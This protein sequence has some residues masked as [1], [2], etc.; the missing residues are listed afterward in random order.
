MVDQEIKSKFENALEIIKDLYMF[1]YED[2]NYYFFKH[3]LTR[4][5][6]KIQKTNNDVMSKLYGVKNYKTLCIQK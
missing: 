4:E 1:M 5:Y 2:E 3:Q 6:M